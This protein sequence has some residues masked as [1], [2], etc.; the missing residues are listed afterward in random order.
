MKRHDFP[1]SSASRAS[2]GFLGIGSILST[3]HLRWARF[4]W[5][6]L[7]V[8]LVL[9][10]AGMLFV[11]AMD[12][13]DTRFQRLGRV[14][15]AGHLKKVVVSVPF[16]IVG[17]LTRPRWLRR[18]SYLLYGVC[19][20]F[21]V[22]VL[23][24]GVE[25]NHARRWIQL[26]MGFDLQPSELCKLGLILALARVLYRARL[27]R[28]GDY[29]RPMALCIVPMA[30]VMKQPDLG[31]ALTIVPVALGMLYLAGAPG[32][33]IVGSLL[34]GGI[35]GWSAWQFE[36]VRDY[37]AQRIDTWVDS[38]E[39]EELIAERN[40]P[41][42]HTYH[43]RLTIGNGSW[44]GRKL[45]RGVANEAGHLPERDSDSIFAVVAEESGFLGACA[46]LALYLLLV[47]LLMVGASTI[48]ERYTR[49]VVGGIAI[50]FAAHFLINVSVNVGVLPMTGLTLPLLST[51]GSSL[52][53]T[54]AALGIALGL[55]SHHEPSLDE[56]AFRA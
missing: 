56:D 12:E 33:L 46:L 42:F 18:N 4:D 26:P 43:A 22:A 49:L 2:G 38:F 21:L 15:F 6:T 48:R 20:G 50:Y 32:R 40:G 1:M 14:E 9:L 52:L 37:Q 29:L 11:N 13:A 31:T 41:G 3:R 35:A 5:H 24:I 51:G 55:S 54:C 39:P 30:L 19:I 25:R 45:G 36:W 7:T 10:G 34:L 47:V 27:D 8:A 17:I 44:F 23:F 16:L 28:I 53:V